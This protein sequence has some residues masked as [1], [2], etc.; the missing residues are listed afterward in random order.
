M[1]VSYSHLSSDERVLIERLHCV[2]GLSVRRTAKAI[3]RSPSTV[4]REPGRGLWFASNENESYRPYRPDRLKSGPWTSGPFYSALTAQ[5]RA[6]R[7]RSVARRPRRMD[8]GRL[9]SWVLDALRR[10][11]SPQLISGR[12]RVEH[13]HDPEMRTGHECLYRWIYAREQR[14]L[15]LRQ[16]LALGRKRRR[17]RSGRGVRGSR[18]P[19]R[20]PIG[21]RPR[22]V[23]SRLEPGHWESDTVVGAGPSRACISTHVERTSRVLFARLVPDRS[24]IATARAEYEI[25][26]T[27]PPEL[28]LD[29]TWDNGGEASLHHLVDDALGMAAYFADPYSSWQRGT[30]ENRNGRLRRYLPRKTA[31]DAPARRELDEIVGEINDTPMKALGYRT[32]NE[33]WQ[34]QVD[35]AASPQ[36]HPPASVAL[37]N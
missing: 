32:P 3:G 21:D 17:R 27:V 37:L 1:G 33:V 31:F 18:I 34:Q 14:H 11:W 4:S 2:Q 30:N 10:G 28:R 35:A 22:S 20:V 8:S 25:Y 29:R 15:D 19:M 12:L 26:R 5:R 16:Y 13:P 36:H 9:R 24:A 6:E 23:D 7:R